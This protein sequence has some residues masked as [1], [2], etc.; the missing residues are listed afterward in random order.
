M[1]KVMPNSNKKC[2]FR[3]DSRKEYI[4]KFRFYPSFLYYR[5]DKWLKNMSAMGW[6]IVHCGIFFFWFEKGNPESKEYFT[7]GLSVQEGKYNISLMYP[8]LEKAYGVKSK[9]S[10]INANKY[11]TLQIVEIDADKVDINNN[12]GYKEL[13]HDRN[14]LY[15]KYFI[16]WFGFA[17]ALIVIFVVIAFIL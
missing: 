10:K 11:K 12:S 7:Y 17:L 8:S 6:H 15:W 4:K 9:K 14:S 3:R 13:I 2:G 1:R 16:K 5:L